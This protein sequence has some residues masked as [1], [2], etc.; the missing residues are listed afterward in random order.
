MREPERGGRERGREIW[1]D[2]V[3]SVPPPRQCVCVSVSVC[4]PVSA[5][6]D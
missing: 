6:D 5:L 1:A 4:I 2:R 3:L